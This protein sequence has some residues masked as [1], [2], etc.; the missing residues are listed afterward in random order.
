MSVQGGGMGWGGLTRRR[1]GLAAA[2]LGLALPALPGSQTGGPVPGLTMPRPRSLEPPPRF[3]PQSPPFPLP[4]ELA[5]ISDPNA[6]APG[7]PPAVPLPPAVPPA[8]V[9]GP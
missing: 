9:V 6:V 8:G 3:I 4:R 7:A 1:P 5:T 2:G